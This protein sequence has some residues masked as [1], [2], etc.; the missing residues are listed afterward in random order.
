VPK[1]FLA[2]M[3]CGYQPGCFVA[4]V[5]ARLD[6]ATYINCTIPC[7]QLLNQFLL[8]APD[9]LG[10]VLATTFPDRKL[11]VILA[12]NVQIHQYNLTSHI[13]TT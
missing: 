13:Y 1:N 6:W 9:E 2:Q 11:S 3:H 5:K 7:T 4:C 12:Q 10:D 8:R